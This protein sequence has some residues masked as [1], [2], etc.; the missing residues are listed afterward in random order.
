MSSADNL[1]V[2]IL[3]TDRV[4]IAPESD[5]GNV[6]LVKAVPRIGESI[7][8]AERRYRIKDIEHELDHP[9][10]HS[11]TLVVESDREI[12]DVVIPRN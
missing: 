6:F 8:V 11:L 12:G 5:K 4:V 2:S 9:Q 3:T 7:R 10:G 1:A